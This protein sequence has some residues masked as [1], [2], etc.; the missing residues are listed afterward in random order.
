VFIVSVIICSNY[1][2]LQFLHQMF[3]V[4]VQQPCCWTTHS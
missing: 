4:V 2:M 3:N 1:H